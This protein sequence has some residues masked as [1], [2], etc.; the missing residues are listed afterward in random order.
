MDKTGRN[1]LRVG[2]LLQDNF[3]ELYEQL[4]QKHQVMINTYHFTEDISTDEKEFFEAVEFLKELNIV[5]GEYFLNKL[6]KEG[7]KY[8]PKARRE[9]CWI[10]ILVHS[11][12]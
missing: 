5:N 2:D 11:H 10:L 3:K 7:K 9:V 4:R 12:L 6:I 1:A 8:W